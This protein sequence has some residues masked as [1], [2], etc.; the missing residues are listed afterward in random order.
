VPRGFRTG[1]HSCEQPAI[2]SLNFFSCARVPQMGEQSEL[3]PVGDLE[4]PRKPGR[5]LTS[6]DTLIAFS[7]SEGDT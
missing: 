4:N 5:S 7:H 1:T 6:G 3:D 2:Q